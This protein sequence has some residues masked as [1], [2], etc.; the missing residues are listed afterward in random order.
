VDE[1]ALYLHLLGVVSI[2]SGMAIAGASFELA[3]RRRRPSEIALLLAGARLAVV[4]L[5]AGVLVAV[6]CGLWLVHLEGIGYGRGWVVAAILLLVVSLALGGLGGQQPRRA[7]LLARRLA[8]EGDAESDDL[9]HLLDDRLA[10]TLNWLSAAAMLAVMA[11]MVWKP[12]F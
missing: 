8:A 5:A 4:L 10:M 2:F 12:G 6:G 9:R 1:L 7:R 11:L 3:R